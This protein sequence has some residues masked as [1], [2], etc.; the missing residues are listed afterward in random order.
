MKNTDKALT[1]LK[2]LREEGKG[3][4]RTRM[5]RMNTDPEIIEK[6]KNRENPTHDGCGLQPYV[7]SFHACA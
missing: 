6:N 1:L 2:G 7:L 5:T 4:K 3:Q